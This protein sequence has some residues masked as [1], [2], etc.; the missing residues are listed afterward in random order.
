MRAS[1][2]R[3]RKAKTEILRHLISVQDL[4]NSDEIGQLDDNPF[5]TDLDLKLIIVKT[6]AEMIE[7]LLL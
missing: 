4:A 5:V 2:T 6:T 1:Y 7:I 3:H